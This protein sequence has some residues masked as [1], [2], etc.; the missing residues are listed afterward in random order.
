MDLSTIMQVDFITGIQRVVR[1]ITVRMTQHTEH[2]FYLLTYSCKNNCFLRLSNERFLDYFLEG[3]GEKGAILTPE[4]IGYR[5]IPSGA[6][7]FELDSVWNALLKRSFLFPV[8]K[9]NGVKIVTQVYDLIPITDPKFCHEN[10]CTNFMVYIGAN[11]K[12]AN[13]IIPPFSVESA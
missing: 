2:E 10:T 6:V 4:K 13:L 7:F 11:L 9:Q 5:D 3:K 12:Y 1:E 8:L